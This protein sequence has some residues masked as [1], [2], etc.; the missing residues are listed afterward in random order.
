MKKLW[1]GPWRVTFPDLPGVTLSEPVWPGSLPQLHS[2]HLGKF[3]ILHQSHLKPVSER[4][5]NLS[6][7]GSDYHS[8]M[9]PIQSLIEVTVRE[10]FEEIKISQHIYKK[11]AMILFLPQTGIKWEKV[12]SVSSQQTQSFPSKSTI[13]FFC[14]LAF[15]KWYHCL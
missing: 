6:A 3:F 11:K 4:Y 8:S 1:E 12:A 7:G 15:H 14:L 5:F 10:S 13:Q 2:T 9:L